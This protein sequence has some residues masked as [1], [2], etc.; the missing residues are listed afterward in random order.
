MTTKFLS[1]LSVSEN[2]ALTAAHCFNVNREL[3]VIYLLVG[4]HDISRGDDTPYATLYASKRII[5][6]SAY[7]PTSDDQNNDVALVMTVDPIRWKRTIGPACLP[8][9]Y[10]GYNTYFDGYPLVGKKMRM[11]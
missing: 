7:V 4:E 3:S 11:K 8:Y 1:N 5:R 9:L 10:K 6:H 2:Y